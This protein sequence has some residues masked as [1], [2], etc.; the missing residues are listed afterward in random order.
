MTP[1]LLLRSREKVPVIELSTLSGSRP[2]RRG[3]L[4]PVD[5]GTGEGKMNVRASRSGKW[6]PALTGRMGVG[7]GCLALKRQAIQILP[8]QGIGGASGAQ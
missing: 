5:T 6:G 3:G 7:G 8:F 1:V 2:K 4:E